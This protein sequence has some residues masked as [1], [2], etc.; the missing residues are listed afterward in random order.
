METS[1]SKI[2]HAKRLAVNILICHSRNCDAFGGNNISQKTRTSGNSVSQDQLL[3]VM[4]LAYQHT[5][6]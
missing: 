2:I 3:L 4:L 6:R 1:S 5:S